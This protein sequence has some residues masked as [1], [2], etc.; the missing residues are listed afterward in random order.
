MRSID[1]ATTARSQSLRATPTETEKSLWYKLRGRRLGG[2]KF[3]RQFPIGPYF[4]D[5]CCR[6]VMLVVEL[7]GSQH[8]ESAYDDRRDAFIVEQGYSVLR[9]WNSDVRS[10]ISNVCDTI[11]AALEKRLVAGERYKIG[12]K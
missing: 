4:A 2:Y 3:V 12:R 8:I 11:V 10:D 9:F 6:D 7:D 1:L 5:F